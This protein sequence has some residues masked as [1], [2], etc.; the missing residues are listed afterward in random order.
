MTKTLLS[1]DPRQAVEEMIKLTEGLAMLIE[2]ESAAVATND[3][4]T[5]TTNEM[6]K[7]PAIEAYETAAAEFR[8]RINEF[9][10]VD[11]GLIE[12]LEAAQDSLKGSTVSNLKLLEKFQEEENE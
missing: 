9:R 6:V 10:Q 7:E 2:A 4:T 5:F 3:G 11:K 1:S 8:T 12:K